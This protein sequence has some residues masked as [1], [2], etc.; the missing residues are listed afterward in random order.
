MIAYHYSRTEEHG[1]AA[2]WLEK[3]GDRAANIYANETAIDNYQEARRRLDLSGV[4]QQTL[5][6]LDEKLGGVLAT[7][8]RY[9]G[10]L[11]VL[12]GLWSGQPFRYDGVH[13]RVQEVTCLP[14]PLQTP[15][16][17]PERNAD[18]EAGFYWRSSRFP[19]WTRL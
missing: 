4:D 16:L 19:S 9:D 3:A 1:E 2:E 14:R 8:A 15:R 18:S 13:Y 10:A 6:R 12:V 5:A 17:R 7:V 11:E